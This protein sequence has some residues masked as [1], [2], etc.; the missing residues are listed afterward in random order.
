MLLRSVF[1]SF[2]ETRDP[3][4]CIRV[5][6]ALLAHKC[7]YGEDDLAKEVENYMNKFMIQ[8][9]D[10][11]HN[12]LNLFISMLQERDSLLSSIIEFPLER[13]MS[14]EDIM[15]LVEE[16]S[17]M[18]NDTAL[19]SKKFVESEDNIKLANS[20]MDKINKIRYYN[21]SR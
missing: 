18:I 20:L 6:L 12:S 3:R 16:V 10:T 4:S 9:L 1:E 8:L 13:K 17:H 7:V 21:V 5:H 2:K 11:D 15:C 19:F 14:K